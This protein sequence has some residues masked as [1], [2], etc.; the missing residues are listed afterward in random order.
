MDLKLDF[1]PKREVFL[2]PIANTDSKKERPI[3]FLPSLNKARWREITDMLEKAKFESVGDVVEF[4][5]KL[6]GLSS[7]DQ[8]NRFTDWLT[9]N[10]EKTKSVFFTQSFP[11]I[12]NS[13]L[14][15]DHNFPSGR[16]ETFPSGAKGSVTLN[17]SQIST[18]LALSFTSQL[19]PLLEH[20]THNMTFFVGW[21]CDAQLRCI[22][23]YF[24]MIHEMKAE[25]QATTVT[26]SRR[27]LNIEYLDSLFSQTAL[28]K[29]NK[30]LT[31]LKFLPGGIELAEG[32]LQTDFANE[33][34]GGGVMQRGCVQE[35]IMFLVKP[36]C[37]VSLV[38][39]AVMQPN[40]AI[41]ISGTRTYSEYKGYG[42]SFRWTKPFNGK[43]PS[44]TKEGQYKTSFVAIDAIYGGT[45]GEAFLIQR[46]MHKAYV[47]FSA[48][49]KE[50][51]FK[52]DTVSTGKW[53][54]G[55]FRGTPVIK[56]IVQW[57]A[58]TLAG[59]SVQFYP[60]DNN[61]N[62]KL[63]ERLAKRCEN[64]TVSELYHLLTQALKN[65]SERVLTAMLSILDEK[66]NVDDE[67]KEELSID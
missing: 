1:I 44:L 21:G 57:I 19:P 29:N 53:G 11:A 52:T 4:Y 46:E 31:K 42:F 3:L 40:E 12:R 56:L 64:L 32:T 15:L 14:A 63:L 36:E 55:A 37:L 13:L 23:N 65:T 6:S 2:K 67:K 8:L 38:L 9:K 16:I 22:L 58:A 24:A 48:D 25:I 62:D 43:L 10:D 41:V 47:G 27:V 49:E 17:R 26:F 50:V 28:L 66:C 18:L 7:E 39:F 54:C 51:G 20:N 5:S 35:E 61:D 30:P 60:W 33:Y 34:I 59:R 45:Q